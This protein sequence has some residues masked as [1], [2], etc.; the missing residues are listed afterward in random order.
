MRCFIQEKEREEQGIEVCHIG[1][2]NRGCSIKEEGREVFRAGG[3]NRGF[4]YKRKELRCYIQDEGRETSVEE[5]G[6]DG[7]RKEERRP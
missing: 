6:L 2:R 4:R 5:E 7:D 1:V 3:R